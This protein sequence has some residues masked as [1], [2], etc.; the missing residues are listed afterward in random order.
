MKKVFI[1]LYFLITLFG[2]LV[3]FRTPNNHTEYENRGL[4]KFS[5]LI[6]SDFLNE[7]FQNNFE[8]S[9]K[10]QFWSS[11]KVK[12]ISNSKNTI[13]SSKSMSKN[14]CLNNYVKIAGNYYNFNCDDYIVDKPN[15]YSTDEMIKIINN[16]IESYNKMGEYADLYYYFI[17]R[18]GNFDFSNNTKTFSI[19]DYLDENYDELD[20]KNYNDYKKYFYKSDHHW[21]YKGSYNGYKD[22]IKLMIGNDE[23]AID[24]N[25]EKTFDIYFNGSSARVT[26]FTKF[27]EKFTVYTFNIPEHTVYIDGVYGRYGNENKYLRGNYSKEKWTNH[28][29][30]YYGGDHG[31]IIFDF[32]NHSKDNLL[33]LSSSYSNPVNKLIASHFNK[34]YVIDL[35]HYSN[36]FN[37]VFD[38]KKYIKE[39]K[40]DKV[41]VICD[42]G[43]LTNSK[44]ELMEVD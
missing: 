38:Y 6:V 36:V 16:R 23:K 10:D 15:D 27:K 35:R 13:L 31:E 26:T 40:I 17:N 5:P 44:F 7:S 3:L 11:E 2:F 28:Y 1:I 4:Y 33:I 20:I 9:F 41:L 37:K 24:I 14:I 29:E 42:I 21:N 19:S 39:N 34:T 25:Q 8:N 22:I 12:A 18:V 43:Y 32:D 30:D